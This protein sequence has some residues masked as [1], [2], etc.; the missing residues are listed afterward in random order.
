[1]RRK[2]A[3]SGGPG[4]RATSGYASRLWV[5]P[6]A[7]DPARRRRSA[8][9]IT[10][11]RDVAALAWPSRAPYRARQA[12]PARATGQWGGR[13]G[14]VPPAPPPQDPPRRRR[15]A[16]APRPRPARPLPASFTTSR[17]SPPTPAPA[18]HPHIRHMNAPGPNFPQRARSARRSGS[19]CLRRSAT[20]AEALEGVVLPA[21]W[22]APLRVRP[23]SR[24]VAECKAR[25]VEEG[26]R[27]AA[28]THVRSIRLENETTSTAPKGLISNRKGAAAP[29]PTRRLD[30]NP[31]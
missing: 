27:R 14:A 4:E 5:R 26:G 28:C 25:P 6:I 29:A 10:G 8:P 21:A 1:M 7:R 23:V 17:S 19:R 30:Q 31:K 15:P 9:L 18:L 11:A 3:S 16:A 13:R 2:K 12:F 24:R 22:C 20:C